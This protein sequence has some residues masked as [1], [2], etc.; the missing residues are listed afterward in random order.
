MSAI[1]L[2]DAQYLLDAYVR[3]EREILLSGQSTALGDRTLTRADLDQVRAGRAEWEGKVADLTAAA[4]GQSSGPL[5][6][7]RYGVPL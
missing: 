4:A 5:G 2:S 7:I 3:A 1:A 6:R